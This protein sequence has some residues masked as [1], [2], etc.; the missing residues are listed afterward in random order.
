MAIR[1]QPVRVSCELP[2]TRT[3]FDAEGSRARTQALAAVSKRAMAAFVM[4]TGASERTFEKKR[5]SGAVMMTWTAE[6]PAG[7]T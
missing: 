2:A 7:M 4:V 1:L 6:P 3:A 5:S